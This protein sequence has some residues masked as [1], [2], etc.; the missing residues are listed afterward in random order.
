MTDAQLKV[1]DG[2]YRRDPPS[3]GARPSKGKIVLIRRGD[4]RDIKVRWEGGAVGWYRSTDL[5]LA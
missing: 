2:V 4:V 1:G 5:K 3:A